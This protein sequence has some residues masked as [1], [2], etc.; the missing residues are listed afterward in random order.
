MKRVLVQVSEATHA[1]WKRVASERGVSMSEVARALIEREVVPG[2]RVM[3]AAVSVPADAP[4][5][6]GGVVTK[7]PAHMKAHRPSVECPCRVFVDGRC[8]ECG[9]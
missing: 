4:A 9:Y 1:D 2:K 5:K 8:Q 3:A 7:G 6:V